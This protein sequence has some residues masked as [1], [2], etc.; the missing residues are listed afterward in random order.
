[1]P[2]RV[3][4][5]GGPRPLQLRHRTPG[6]GNRHAGPRVRP[7]PWARR[8]HTPPPTVTHGCPAGTTDIVL[9]ALSIR[10]ARPATCCPFPT[11]SSWPN[12]HTA[13]ELSNGSVSLCRR[14]PPL[15]HKQTNVS[16]LSTP[17]ASTGCTV[18]PPGQPTGFSSTWPRKCQTAAGRCVISAAALLP[19]SRSC[20]A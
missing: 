7:Q 13:R 1:M 3:V 18:F 10:A 9:R 5:A 8:C 12:T 6:R 17:I 19:P 11:V 16:P 2:A 14:V 15:P 4:W 20:C